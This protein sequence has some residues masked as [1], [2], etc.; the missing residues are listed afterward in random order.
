M[1]MAYRS[2]ETAMPLIHKVI[3]EMRENNSKA[4][5]SDIRSVTRRPARLLCFMGR[6]G[7]HTF[8]KFKIYA[9]VRGHQHHKVWSVALI[10]W[11]GVSTRKTI[12]KL[13][14]LTEMKMRKIPKLQRPSEANELPE[15]KEKQSE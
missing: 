10:Y 3:M 1:R 5:G 9:P 12:A 15:A 6:P 13:R 11:P 8:I 2:A 7:R 14:S 4:E